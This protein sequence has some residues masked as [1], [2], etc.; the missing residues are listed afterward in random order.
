MKGNVLSTISQY[1]GKGTNNQAE[2]RAIIAGLKSAKELKATEVDISI[3]SELIEKQISGEYSVK[4][5]SL[6]PLYN[7]LMS[8]LRSFD[9]YSISHVSHDG[10]HEAHVL[11]QQA[12][13]ESSNGS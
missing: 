11:A 1:I 9:S 3:D 4:N 6:R 2:Y 8:Y 5:A 13:K 10:N 7:E 12:L